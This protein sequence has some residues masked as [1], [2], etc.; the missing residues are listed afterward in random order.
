[1]ESLD[2]DVGVGGAGVEGAGLCAAEISHTGNG[3]ARAGTEP[4]FGKDRALAQHSHDGTCPC[5]DTALVGSGGTRGLSLEGE[6]VGLGGG[7]STASTE[8]RL[9]GVAEM[10]AVGGEVNLSSFTE[11][12]GV[13]PALEH[14]HCGD[15]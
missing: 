14:C 11:P 1:M 9:S 3:T 6:D 8:D 13:T 5:R 2:G 12:S 15:R 7:S 4:A 10:R